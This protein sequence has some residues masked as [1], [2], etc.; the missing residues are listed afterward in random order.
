MST[1]DR[2]RTLIFAGFLLFLLALLTGLLIGVL[3][4]PRLAQG[5]HIGGLMNGMFLVILGLAW[6]RLRLGARAGSWVSGLVLFGTYA[7]WAFTL[8]AAVLGTGKLTP[9][10]SG[11]H[12]ADPWKEALVGAGLI[13]LAVSMIIALVLIVWA[14]RKA[15]GREG[16]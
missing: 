3:P 8:L 7:N 16:G 12:L 2:S 15:S 1:P 5:S 4:Y 10:A 13:S 11:G 6:E 9:L 14:L